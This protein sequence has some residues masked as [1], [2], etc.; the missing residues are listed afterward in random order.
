MFP[1]ASG[2]LVTD[3]PQFRWNIG[4]HPHRGQRPDLYM[5]RLN[6]ALGQ[7]YGLAQNYALPDFRAA[8]RGKPADIQESTVHTNYLSI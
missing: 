6:R 8:H 1:S 5:A 4:F 3:S 2:W 7:Q